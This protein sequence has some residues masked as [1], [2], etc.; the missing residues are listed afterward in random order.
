MLCYL[1]CLFFF[2]VEFIVCYSIKHSLAILNYFFDLANF[3]QTITKAFQFSSY[4]VAWE[5]TIFKIK[6]NFMTLNNKQKHNVSMELHSYNFPYWTR[7]FS[8]E[9][10]HAPVKLLSKHC[11]YCNNISIEKKQ[12]NNLLLIL[13][14]KF[15][16]TSLQPKN[17]KIYMA[18]GSALNL[19]H[20]LLFL[21][22]INFPFI[23]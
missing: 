18:Q 21:Y 8:L 7:S 15:S 6:R 4:G 13:N 5:I 20:F 12:L 2:F 23:R 19:V 3:L 9:I 17:W 11:S 16:I 10:S 22:W 14:S 1:F